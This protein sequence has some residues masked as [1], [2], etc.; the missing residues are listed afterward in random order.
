MGFIKSVGDTI[1][2]VINS[3]TSE[4]DDQFNLI[5]ESYSE[6]STSEVSAVIEGGGGQASNAPGTYSIFNPFNVFRY[7]RFGMNLTGGAYNKDA[8]FD[9]DGSIDAKKIV[10]K[11]VNV[12]GEIQDA[13]FKDFNDAKKISIENPTASTIIQWAQSQGREAIKGER[14]V[15]TPVPYAA[16]DFIWCKYYGKVP[17]NRLV[18]LRRYPFPI[19]DDIRI[20]EEV[21]PP[22]PL[23]QALTWFGKDVDNDL[24]SIINLKW[25]LNWKQL[26]TEMT[27]VEGNEINVDVLL[28]ELKIDPKSSK[29]KLARAL[30][31]DNVNLAELSG[32][33]SLAQ[34]YIRNSYGS[35]GPYWNRILG[36]VNVIDKTLIRDRGFKE[37]PPIIINFDYSLRSYGGINPKIAFLDLLTNFLSLT[38][39][40]ASFWGGGIRYFEKTGPKLD[41]YGMEEHMLKGN[42]EDAVKS[43]INALSSMMSQNLDKVKDAI[44]AI[45]SEIGSGLDGKTIEQIREIE[46]VKSAASAEINRRS[47]ETG[48]DEEGRSKAGLISQFAIQ[49]M[50]NFMRKP[51]M[52]RSILDGRE[53]GEW[54]LTVGNP[55]SPIAMIGNLVCDDVEMTVGETLGIDDF[56][57]E[58]RFKVTLKHGRPRAKQDIESMFNLG[59]G[60]MSFSNLRAPSS[61]FNSYGSAVTDRI[62][63]ST[64]P[65][66]SKLESDQAAISPGEGGYTA[67]VNTGAANLFGKRITNLYGAY[68]QSPILPSYFTQ[69]KTKG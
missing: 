66:K 63:E 19:S 55:M 31:G 48:S 11:D 51:L 18:T 49:S 17:N 13:V 38:N 24:N 35:N 62:N 20:N 27:D 64:I 10:L 2:G 26:T 61:S 56:P 37:Q 59:K 33:D 34:E 1:N 8:H 22:I 39:N 69:V 43:G 12:D 25:G 32:F 21:T 29:G 6:E 58:F 30:L 28:K 15:Q 42:M 45:E 54:H 68:G 7:S 47:G 60:Q 46:Q 14:S 23:A 16:E 57:T 53:I 50:E 44:T 52:M 67:E 3:I 36:P 40:T 4:A 41:L 5:K 9:N 65:P